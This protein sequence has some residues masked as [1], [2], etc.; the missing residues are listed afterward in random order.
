[1]ASSMNGAASAMR[2]FFAL[3]SV[4]ADE[5]AQA[6]PV[7][8]DPIVGVGDDDLAFLQFT[9]GS[10][11]R[12]KGVMVTHQNLAA[13]AHAIMFDGLRSTPERDKGVSWLPLYHDMG[14]IGFVIAPHLRR[15]SR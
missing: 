1:M 7:S 2:A 3:P 12:P 10:T 6:P 11:S 8:G 4:R 15:R 5:I 14:L 9:S 13:N